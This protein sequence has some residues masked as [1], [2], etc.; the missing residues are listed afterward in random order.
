MVQDDIFL[1]SEADAWFN[2]NAKVLGKDLENDFPLKLIDFL[3]LKPKK[4]LDVGAA[5]GYRIAELSRRLGSGT[6]VAIEPSQAAIKDGQKRFPFIEFRRGLMYDL[7]LH[8]NEVFDLV[9]VHFVFHW[10]SRDKLLG[11]VAEL[12]RAIAD[13][14]YLI[15]G[16]FLPDVPTKVRYHHLPGEVVFTY[17]QDYAEIFLSSGLYTHIARLTFN[18]DTYSLDPDVGGESRGVYSVLRKNKENLYVMKTFQKNR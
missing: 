12:D 11:S 6:Y 17:K 7:P 4:V 16:D 9:I 18:H 1:N 10:I 5:N 13:G 2:S 14:G 3:R 8:D 15:L